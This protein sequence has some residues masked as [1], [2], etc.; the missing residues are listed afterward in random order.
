MKLIFI[1]TS[2]DFIM[3]NELCEYGNYRDFIL[4]GTRRI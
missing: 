1:L 4:N 3:I 2:N